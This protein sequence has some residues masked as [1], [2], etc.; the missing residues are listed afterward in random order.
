MLI[1]INGEGPAFSDTGAVCAGKNGRKGKG[2]LT[3]FHKQAGN[4][5]LLFGG[6][7]LPGLN[8]AAQSPSTA[9]PAHQSAV[10][11]Q[12][13]PAASA[14]EPPREVTPPVRS[15][16]TPTPP[17][18][19]APA[20]RS[21][22]APE[23]ARPATSVHA[24]APTPRHDTTGREAG[25]SS[26]G[27]SEGRGSAAHVDNYAPETTHTRSVVLP[28][29]RFP[30]NTIPAGDP[31][32]DAFASDGQPE[33]NT[34]SPEA[35]SLTN[36]SRSVTGE[37]N[38]TDGGTPHIHSPGAHRPIDLPSA[39]L[40]FGRPAPK[41]SQTIGTISGSVV[42][43]RRD[44]TRSDV[45]V[46]S[47]QDG[48]VR[49]MIIHHGVNGGERVVALSRRQPGGRVV[50]E[51]GGRGY[52]ERRFEY[53]RHPYFR[54]AYYSGGRAYNRYYSMSRY[55]R[56]V[57]SVYAPASY[58]PQAYYHW[59]SRAWPKPVRYSWS[60]TRS[61]WNSHYRHYFAPRTAY[62]SAV[63]WL[64]D[65]L[66]SQSLMEDYQGPSGEVGSDAEE[67]GA[68]EDEAP[69]TPEVRDLIEQQVQREVDA[70]SQA[71]KN[72]QADSNPSNAQALETDVLPQIFVAGED[73][74]VIT[75]SSAECAVSAGDT[76][77]LVAPPQEEASAASVVVLSS[78]GGLE[79][80]EGFLIS[81]PI[82]DLI[83]MQNHTRETID[84]G[85][86]ELRKEQGQGGLP[87][88]PAA[89]QAKRVRAAFVANAPPPEPDVAAQLKAVSQQAD[90]AEQQVV[91]ELAQSGG[92]AP[93]GATP[94]P[95]VP[96]VQVPI[97]ESIEE[98]L[99]RLGLPAQVTSF[100]SITIYGYRDVQIT[101]VDGKVTGVQ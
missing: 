19:A 55:H 90:Q 52:V 17:R 74:D 85:L 92:P 81:I 40:P 28:D 97:G 6:I 29:T 101:F 7:L 34:V 96:S 15:A 86:A 60:W 13:R 35:R 68:L 100:G 9:P 95:A 94:R 48:A 45:R 30:G 54:R 89:A 37:P 69:I 53:D 87:A 88:L 67:A 32:S 77:Q 98:V 44:G 70:E 61:P 12:T 58:F 73:L 23:P 39:A 80:H 1:G 5:A 79:C 84:Q 63:A 47:T 2:I 83:E 71:G 66:I 50:I 18:E 42:R 91:T 93:E 33:P 56:N 27:R 26:A 31:E 43:V 11:A 99:A 25:S 41:D 78:K 20:V 76:V 65:Y 46:A 36:G 57:L 3:L 51:R 62:S 16:P 64:A 75:D 10:T 14:P 72:A 38:T 82:G 24:P 4:V 49:A 8:V 59:V 21:E 22:P